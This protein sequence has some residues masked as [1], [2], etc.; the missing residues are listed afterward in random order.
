MINEG[1]IE[2][3]TILISNLRNKACSKKEALTRDLF[4]NNNRVELIFASSHAKI[5]SIET[6]DGNYYTIEGSGNLSFNSRIEQYIIDND[7]EL[8]D[9]HNQWIKE[10]LEFFKGKKHLQSYGYDS[11]KNINT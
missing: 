7:K 5:I 2:D 6:Y 1:L 4:M 9:F 10:I 11:N 8:Y 3:A